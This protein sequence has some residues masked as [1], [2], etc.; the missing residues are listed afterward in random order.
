MLLPI[1]HAWKLSYCAVFQLSPLLLLQSTW[2]F[3]FVLGVFFPISFIVRLGL[4][5]G[6]RAHLGDSSW[7]NILNCMLDSQ[8]VTPANLKVHTYCM[9]CGQPFM[10]I[11]IWHNLQNQ[12]MVQL[13][14]PAIFIEPCK[15][16]SFVSQVL[17]EFTQNFIFVFNTDLGYPLNFIFVFCFS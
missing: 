13:Y 3:I 9:K 11:C 5:V 7:K 17:T 8:P 2:V 15:I 4:S 10:R 14:V 16:S 6:G 1:Y 12:G